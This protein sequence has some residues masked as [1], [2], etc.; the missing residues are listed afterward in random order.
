MKLNDLLVFI[1]T[2]FYTV[3]IKITLKK[4]HFWGYLKPYQFFLHGI[5]VPQIIASE[6][7]STD[8]KLNNSNLE[9]QKVSGA[10]GLL[11]SNH[12]R[13]C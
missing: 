7:V 11:I 3:S 6:K 1:Y 2:G 4:G 9:S 10:V 12:L 5:L 8:P 13:A